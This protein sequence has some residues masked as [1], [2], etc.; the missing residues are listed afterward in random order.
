[1]VVVVVKKS[2]AFFVEGTATKEKPAAWDW[3]DS[4]GVGVGGA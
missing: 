2:S 3:S 4:E 1:V